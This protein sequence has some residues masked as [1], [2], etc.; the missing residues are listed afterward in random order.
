MSYGWR[1]LTSTP[2]PRRRSPMMRSAVMMAV[3]DG[4]AVD[5]IDVR[6]AAQKRAGATCQIDLPGP[7]RRGTEFRSHQLLIRHHPFVPSRGGLRIMDRE[8]DR[9]LH[10]EAVLLESGDVLAQCEPVEAGPDIS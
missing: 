7:E 2:T 9:F 6:L 5:A 3:S 1:P 8:V 4:D 10:V